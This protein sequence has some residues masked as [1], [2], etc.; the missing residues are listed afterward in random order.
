M[1]D[2]YVVQHDTGNTITN[3]Q[4][5]ITDGSG[6]APSSALPTYE[7]TAAAWN[8]DAYEC[9]FCDAEFLYLAQLNQHL[10]SPRHSKRD[11]RLYRCPGP[12]CSIQTETLFGLVQHVE[13]GS[14]GIRNARQVRNAMDNFTQGLSRMRIGA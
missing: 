9:Y 7:A 1:I 11:Q 6:R 2:D 14:C 12:G 8:G 10:N 13:R 3:P 5:M 4:R